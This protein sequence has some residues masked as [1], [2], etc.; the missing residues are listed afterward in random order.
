M[1]HR[2]LYL[3]LFSLA[4]SACSS[5]DPKQAAGDF[6]YAKTPESKPLV[7]PS[8]LDKPAKQRKYSISN[9]INHQGPIGKKMDIRAPSL[10]LPVAAGSRVVE[11]SGK[12]VVWFDK[13]L[14]EEDLLAFIELSVMNQLM[15]DNVG[16]T[17]VSQNNT[18]DTTVDKKDGASNRKTTTKV[19]E[20]DWYN[21]DVESGWLYSS[22]DSSTSMKF[23][24]TLTTKPHGRS[25]SL[26]VELIKYMKTDQ[27]GGSNEMN[28]IDQHR[29]E[30][31]VVNELI[32]QVDYD[33]RKKQQENRFIRANEKLVTIGENAAT[34]MAYIVELD[35]DNLWDNMPVF[36]ERHGFTI[37]DLN[38][39]NKIYY[40]EFT[41]PDNS[42]WTSIWG[43]DVPVIDVNDAHYQFVLAPLD[44]KNERTSVTIYNAEGKPLPLETLERIFPVMEKGLSFRHVY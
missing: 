27:F 1:N 16:Y 38:E 41:K 28:P 8:D 7:I 36:F 15:T 17:V 25:L 5:G 26:E 23:R 2:F 9:K 19:Y 44:E 3:A 20:S 4:V 21:D 18:A 29:A 39:T 10:V 12:S 14:E 37:T 30:M 42:M 33:Y 34:E 43:E 13:V 11:E 22:I 6:D 24:Y 35:L 40:V 31:A 32:A